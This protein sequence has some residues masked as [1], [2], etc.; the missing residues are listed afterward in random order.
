MVGKHSTVKWYGKF[1]RQAHH[2]RG[3]AI[4]GPSF[5]IYGYHMPQNTKTTIYLDENDYRRLKALARAQGRPSA[6]LVRE[7]VAL[8]V[9]ARSSIGRPASIA[10]AHSGK[11]DLSE[12]S[13]VGGG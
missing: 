12:R 11:G 9:R 4:E 8:Y 1:A 6:E 13:R 2:T 10:S 3:R 5:T 7:A